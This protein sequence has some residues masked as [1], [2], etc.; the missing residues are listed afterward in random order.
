MATPYTLGYQDG[1]SYRRHDAGTDH[2]SPFLQGY[3]DGL[4]YRWRDSI[5]DKQ[6]RDEDGR[7][8]EKQ[9][10]SS[11]QSTATKASPRKAKPSVLEG[12][13]IDDVFKIDPPSESN[14]RFMKALE[15]SG[16]AETALEYLDPDAISRSEVKGRLESAQKALAVMDRYG[17]DEAFDADSMILDVGKSIAGQKEPPSIHEALAVYESF[18]ETIAK[19]PPDVDKEWITETVNDALSASPSEVKSYLKSE[20]E[21][22][23]GALSDED[24]KYSSASV[25]IY[26]KA[27]EPDVQKQIK[28]VNKLANRVLNSL[29]DDIDR[30]G[31]EREIKLASFGLDPIARKIMKTAIQGET[32]E[33]EA[34]LDWVWSKATKK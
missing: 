31:A 7:F 5:S 12:I 27:L 8:A 33:A 1:L 34:F 4:A 23:S 18:Q 22:L 19:I 15:Q 26:E 20:K 13:N 17:I 29:A 24:R 10:A 9:G 14:Q 32:E 25:S 30:E 21:S 16:D 2:S 11:S 28:G 6:P 3:S